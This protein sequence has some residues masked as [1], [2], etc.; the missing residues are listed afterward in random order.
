MPDDL[1]VKLYRT[2]YYVGIGQPY[3]LLGWKHEEKSIF[4]E[5]YY[6]LIKKPGEF[7]IKK[8]TTEAKESTF[9]LFPDFETL[10][11]KE[12]LPQSSYFVFNNF[13][14]PLIENDKNHYKYEFPKFEKIDA[15]YLYQI[16]KM[17]PN[18][19]GRI[20]EATSIIDLGD[21]IKVILSINIDTSPVKDI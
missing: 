15:T 19:L 9:D 8:M 10:L 7:I 4:V 12:I 11:Q 20:R 3:L 6:F 17:C 18:S 14:L 5:V 1:K 21:Y 16:K 13:V 2:D